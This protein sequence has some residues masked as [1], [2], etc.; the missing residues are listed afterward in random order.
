MPQDLNYYENLSFV[1]MRNGFSL[2]TYSQLHFIHVSV[3]S[4]FLN[5]YT[6]TF[7]LKMA[8]ALYG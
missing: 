8:T 5:G 3:L 2:I 4:Y 7:T 1:H 6:L